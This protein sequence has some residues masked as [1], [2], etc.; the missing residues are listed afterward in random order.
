MKKLFYFVGVALLVASC[1]TVTKTAKTVDAPASL[2]SATVADLEIVPER[3]SYSYKPD[4]SIVR[5]G[6]ENVKQDA[7]Q[8]LLEQDNFNGD[9]LVDANFSIKSTR[10]L[11]FNFINE[12]TVSGHPAKY[13]N[14]HSLN[15]S[16]WCN[17]AF[18]YYYKDNSKRGGGLL[19]NLFGK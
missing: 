1:T 5:G 7:I 18:R 15:D 11:V 19:N 6:M 13:K 16:V 4:A 12:V 8:K 3:I 2:L 14:F 17:P 10:F 9:V